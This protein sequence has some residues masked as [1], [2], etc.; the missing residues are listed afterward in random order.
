MLKGGVYTKGGKDKGKSVQSKDNKAKSTERNAASARSRPS[1]VARGDMS[2]Q[3][4]LPEELD[5]SP[6]R[7]HRITR[8]SA[9][10]S[11]DDIVK[12]INFDE[13]EQEQSS[14]NNNAVPV[15][16]GHANANTPKKGG[17]GGDKPEKQPQ[18]KAVSDP[19][20]LVDP[21]SSPHKNDGVDVHVDPTQSDFESEYESSSESGQ[22]TDDD[23]SSSY[24]SE[25]DDSRGISQSRA[26][27]RKREDDRIRRMLKRTA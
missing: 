4:W 6:S 23:R 14:S 16:E 1:K 24:S 21:D 12:R 20:A 2:P 22:E 15:H 13:I 19:D 25:S 11:R 9:K 5:E 10:E 26:K 27:K 7:G 17:K 18:L 3:S 8:K